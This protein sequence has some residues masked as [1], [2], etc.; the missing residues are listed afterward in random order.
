[1]QGANEEQD[2]RG[3]CFLSFKKVRPPKKTKFLIFKKLPGVSR[4]L[5]LDGYHV[6]RRGRGLNSSPPALVVGGVRA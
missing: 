5:A 2:A 3:T 4:A 1:M 6:L